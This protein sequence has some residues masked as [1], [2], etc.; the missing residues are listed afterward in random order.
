M[1]QRSSYI[2]NEAGNILPDRQISFYV[3]HFHSSSA[4]QKQEGTVGEGIL[5]GGDIQR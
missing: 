4:E 5:V 1:Q 3:V 2:G